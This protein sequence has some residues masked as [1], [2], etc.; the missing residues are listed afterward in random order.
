[1]KY[2]LLLKDLPASRI[3]CQLQIFSLDYF[4]QVVKF[5]LLFTN[6]KIYQ[7]VI[8]RIQQVITKVLMIFFSQVTIKRYIVDLFARISLL[9]Y[10]SLIYIT[11]S[12]HN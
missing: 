7:T 9:D 6:P 10:L 3:N 4:V 11:I 8:Q 2:Y 12:F 1:M 5:V